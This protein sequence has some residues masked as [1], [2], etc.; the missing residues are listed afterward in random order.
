M[1]SLNPV[2][3]V[4][5]QIAQAI[6]LH[7]PLSARDAATEAICAVVSRIPRG[8]VATYGQVATMAGM[9]RRAPATAKPLMNATL[10]PAAAISFADSPS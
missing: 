5:H 1:T 7:R 8:W 2:L 3:T 10:K 4:G 9:P 6:R